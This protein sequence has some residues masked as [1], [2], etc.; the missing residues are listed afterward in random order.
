MC[1]ILLAWQALPDY[2]L[3]VAANRDEY[4]ARAAA[5]AGFWHDSPGLLAGRDLEAK[6]TWMGV[7]RGGRFAA[8]TNYR[9]AREPSAAESRGALVS[10]FLAGSE[11]PAAYVASVARRASSYSGFNLLA[12]DGEDL[13]WMSNRDGAP[14]RLA[15]GLYGLGNLLL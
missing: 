3:A 2:A 1:L 6:G 5:P 12:A 9:G 10:R 4:H 11:A 8:V 15:P 13:W 7:S 14:R